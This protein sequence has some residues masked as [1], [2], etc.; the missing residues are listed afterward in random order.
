MQ[1]KSNWIPISICLG[2]FIVLFLVGELLINSREWYIMNLFVMFWLVYI[3]GQLTYSE[4][5][6]NK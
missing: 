6:E 3:A 1:I 4:W 2:V 5:K